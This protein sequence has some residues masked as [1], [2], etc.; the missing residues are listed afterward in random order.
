MDKITIDS[1]ATV[2]L[3]RWFEGLATEQKEWFC[4]AIDRVNVQLVMPFDEVT[5][6]TNYTQ[7]QLTK[8]QR[9]I[10]V[11]KDVAFRMAADP[12]L[13]IKAER[14]SAE[15]LY[16]VTNYYESLTY[17]NGVFSAVSTVT[18]TLE[19]I[20]DDTF[21]WHKESFHRGNL[22]DRLLG[23]KSNTEFVSRHERQ[24][25]K[26]L[27]F[28]LLMFYMTETK[29]VEVTEHTSVTHKK[30]K[31]PSKGK[32]AKTQVVRIKNTVYVPVFEPQDKRNVDTRPF[33][34][35][36]ESWRVRGHWRTYKNGKKIWIKPQVRGVVESTPQDK[37][38]TLEQ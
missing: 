2:N 13:D 5:V 12:S 17:R 22:Y 24:Q 15:R 36:I 7:P 6:Q 30:A 37:E 18:G 25:N 26:I 23:T 8:E 34:R 11:E 31:K 35:H 19:Q 27:R 16:N 10:E 20:L 1:E 14:A 28:F 33:T 9:K 38:Y 3:I 29:R 4:E 32:K 21:T